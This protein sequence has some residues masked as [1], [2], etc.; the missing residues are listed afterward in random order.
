M[1]SNQLF[2]FAVEKETNTIFI[3]RTF[4]AGLSLVWD[5]FTKPDILD[6]WGAPEPWVVKTK[7][8]NFEVGGRRLYSM[9]NAEGQEYWSI[10]EFTSIT[11]KSNFQMLTNFADK[12]GNVNKQFNSSENNLNFSEANGTTTI[13]ITIKYATSALLEMMIERGFKEGYSMTM[14]NLEKLLAKLN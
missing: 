11:P 7:F 1:N 6:Q 14:D 5:A 10:Q 2:D 4:D 3:T 8:M 9:S 12:D 13:N